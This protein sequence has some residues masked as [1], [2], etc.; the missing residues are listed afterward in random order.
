MTKQHLNDIMKTREVLG[1]L[2]IQKMSLLLAYTA[3]EVTILS[4]VDC[5]EEI[6]LLDKHLRGD[7]A[8]GEKLFG[9]ICSA[10][11]RY[12]FSQTN[13]DTHFTESD[14]EDIIADATD[15]LEYKVYLIKK[16]FIRQK[17]LNGLQ[18]TFFMCP[19]KCI[20][21]ISAFSASEDVLI[22]F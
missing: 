13:N 10:V 6:I 4:R 22:G 5:A 17:R 9:S 11:R 1:L 19:R 8:A 3:D 7:S 14:K 18:S 16:P 21:V 12:V 2:Q 20:K 15:I